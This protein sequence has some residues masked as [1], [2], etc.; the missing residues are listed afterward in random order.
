[1]SKKRVARG[2]AIP[3]AQE[4]KLI[5]RRT[6]TTIPIITRFKEPIDERMNLEVSIIDANA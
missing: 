6:G 1:M 3:E 4:T 2:T 5:I